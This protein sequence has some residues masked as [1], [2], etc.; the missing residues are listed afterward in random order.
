MKSAWSTHGVTMHSSN[1]LAPAA[2]W[3]GEIPSTYCSARAYTGHC[4]GGDHALPVLL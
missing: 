4:D 3:S 2:A 1:S